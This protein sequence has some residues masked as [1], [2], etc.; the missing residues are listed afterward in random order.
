MDMAKGAQNHRKH[1][2]CE[3]ERC[4]FLSRCLNRDHSNAPGPKTQS[5]S[6]EAKQF[7]YMMSLLR[8]SLLSDIAIIALPGKRAARLKTAAAAHVFLGP[9]GHSMQIISTVLGCYLKE[10]SNI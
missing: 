10:A 9:E 8:R 6:L 5:H 1:V 4:V 7:F 3:T 2:R